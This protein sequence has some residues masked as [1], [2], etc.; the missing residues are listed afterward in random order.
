MFAVLVNALAVILGSLLGLAFGRGLN[1]RLTGVAMTGLGLSTLYIGFSGSLKGEN[2]LITIAALVVGGILAPCW[3]LMGRS[4]G[5][6]SAPSGS[7]GGSMA[8]WR[9]AS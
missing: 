6:A 9:R 1:E 3:T 7:P 4:C 8:G 5:W 2:V